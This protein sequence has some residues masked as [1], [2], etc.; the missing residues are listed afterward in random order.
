MYPLT[1]I[2]FLDQR[3][4]GPKDEVVLMY[5]RLVQSP[6]Y[7]SFKYILQMYCNPSQ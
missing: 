2:Q 3:V 4:F 5:S 7:Y 6:C 1:A